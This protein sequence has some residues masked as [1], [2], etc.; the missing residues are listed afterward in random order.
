MSRSEC[1]AA[2]LRY[3]AFGVRIESDVPL[4]GLVKDRCEDSADARIWLAS[5]PPWVD[6]A[7]ALPRSRYRRAD[8]R[9]LRIVHVLGDTEAE[10]FFIT[11]ADGTEFVVSCDGGLVFG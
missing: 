10:F 8:L 1:C 11:Y 5:K 9:A 3:R 7:L 2:P 4:P 6:Y